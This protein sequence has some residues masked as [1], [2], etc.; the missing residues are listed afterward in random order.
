[1][2]SPRKRVGM[3]ILRKINMFQ[4]LPSPG[5]R[6][7]VMFPAFNSKDFKDFHLTE[8]SKPKMQV[9]TVCGFSRM[10]L[11]SRSESSIVQL[12]TLR[13]HLASCA[14]IFASVKNNFQTTNLESDCAQQTMYVN[15]LF[16]HSKIQVFLLSH[17]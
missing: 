4:L 11:G 6:T 13:N 9:N 7:T 2:Y 12:E 5:G 15:V 17:L 16:K 10:G 1:M 8:L 3:L 14:S